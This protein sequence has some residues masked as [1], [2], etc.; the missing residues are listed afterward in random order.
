M[1]RLFRKLERDHHWP[2]AL[3][4]ATARREVRYVELAHDG[5][6][7][8][9]AFLGLREDK[10]AREVVRD[11]P[12]AFWRMTFWVLRLLPQ[13]QLAG[14]IGRRS[15]SAGHRPGSRGF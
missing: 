9:P 6:V 1:A 3:D 7:R 13:T 2:V 4:R 11:L 12:S 5:I 14:R 10:T 15:V 8:H